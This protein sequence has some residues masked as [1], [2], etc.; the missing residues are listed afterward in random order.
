MFLVDD[1][2]SSID[3]AEVSIECRFDLPSPSVALMHDTIYPNPYYG[4]AAYGDCAT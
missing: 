1:K 4:I 3:A 2:Y